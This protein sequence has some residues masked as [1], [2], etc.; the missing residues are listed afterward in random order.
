MIAKKIRK[1][2]KRRAN[3]FLFVLF[4]LSFAPSCV[5]TSPT[6]DDVET[7][8]YNMAEMGQ[9]MDRFYRIYSSKGMRDEELKLLSQMI[10]LQERCTN[11]TPSYLEKDSPSY[12]EDIKLYEHYSYKSLRILKEMKQ[13]VEISDYKL[14]KQLLDQLD[15]NRRNAHQYFG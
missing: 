11:L 14:L 13:A 3:T 7:L 1:K 9:I 10:H 5:H 4:V 8:A 6:R 12:M 15:K 2:S